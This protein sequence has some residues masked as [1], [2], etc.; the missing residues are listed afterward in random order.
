MTVIRKTTAAKAAGGDALTFVMSDDTV[1]RMGDVINPDGWHTDNFKKNPIAL[2]GHRSDFPIG[3][4]RDVHVEKNQL[5][6]KLELAK[7]GTSDRIDEIRRLVEQGILRAVSVG[8]SPIEHEL[9]KDNSG[10]YFKQQELLETSLVSVPANPAAIQL[11]RSLKTSEE[12]IGLVFGEHASRHELITRGVNGE[13]AATETS[14]RKQTTMTPL[15]KRIEDAQERLTALKDQL[16]EHLAK[17]DG[18]EPNETTTATTDELNL[19]IDTHTAQLDS[20]VKAEK[21]LAASTALTVLKPIEGE[22]VNGN[23]R[24]VKVHATAAKTVPPGER[25]LRALVAMTLSHITRGQKPAFQFLLERYGDDGKIDDATRTVFEMVTRTATAPAT[26][27]TSG[28]ASQLVNTEIQGF[29]ALLMPASVYPGLSARGLHLNFGRSGVISI[30]TRTATPNIAGAFVLEGNPIPV[31]QGAF[32]SQTFS[33]KKMAV[34]STWTREIGE[35]S[36]PAIEGLIRNA[37]QEDTSVALDTVLLDA[38]AA[39][40]VRPAGIRAG[41]SVTTATAGGGFAALVGDLKALAAALITASN[42]NI[43]SPVWIMNPIQVL[44][45]SLTQNAGGDFP[46]AA[47][48]NNGRFQGYPIVVSSTV[49]AGM[50]ILLDAADF[51]AIEGGA[52]RFDL[53]D[54]ATLVYDD[55]APAQIGTVATPATVG[56]PARSM[57]QTDSIA[58]RMIMDINWGF[59]RTGTLAWTQAVTW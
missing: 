52:P 54:Q 55:T 11:A 47:E 22:I 13:H 2:F 18:Q 38:T 20:L 35:H 12:V 57:Y 43:R 3:T 50:V 16:T 8:F 31:K 56:A 29:Q 19:K 17:S 40:N 5:V 46:F 30:P 15:S 36:T 41:V 28:W 42:G 33:P 34:I 37:I 23:G 51:V 49:T 48:I 26:T 10:I 58:L 21:S 9:L 24:G 53:S 1:D 14:K 27:F 45:I 25:V 6:G 59:R 44:S 7:Q 32:T 4:W 39:T